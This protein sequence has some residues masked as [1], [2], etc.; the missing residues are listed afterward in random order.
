MQALSGETGH[1]SFDLASVRFCAEK[2][3]KLQIS[4]AD[5]E[6]GISLLEASE[7][8]ANEDRFFQEPSVLE[9]LARMTAPR[10]RLS[11]PVQFVLKLL[12]F[13]QL[14]RNDAI[15]LLGFD[16]SDAVHVAD[17]FDG[18]DHFRGRDVNDR[19][20]H[21]FRIRETL[22]SLFRNLDVE[23]QW[24]R[25][26]HSSLDGKSPLSLLLGGSMEDILLTRDYVDAAAGR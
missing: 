15:S 17:V 23:N 18:L 8:S 1:T 26:P 2:E 9:M 11:G 3:G 24:L 20:A 7:R 22:D 12:D 16:Q 13:W 25:E 10:E 21:L 19:I 6:H 5:D 14:R 4:F